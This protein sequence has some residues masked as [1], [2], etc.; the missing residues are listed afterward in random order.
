MV[1]FIPLL[2]DAIGAGE[3]LQRMH[4]LPAGLEQDPAVGEVAVASDE[5]AVGRLDRRLHLLGD[6]TGQLVVLGAQPPC[7]VDARALGD[8]G[9]L[10][11]G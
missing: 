4:G 10:G 6:P 5:L 8:D 2:G 3:H 1:S 11:A 7:P 9:H